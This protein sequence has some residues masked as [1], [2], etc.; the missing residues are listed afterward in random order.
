MPLRLA[1]AV[2]LLALGCAAPVP[3]PAT[4]PLPG[5]DPALQETLRGLVEG[6]EGEVG[7][8]VRHL[9]TGATAE[10]RADE[11]FPTASLIKVP[12]LIGV[13]DAEARGALDLDAPLVYH[14]SLRRSDGDDLAAYLPTG[15]RIA[16]IKLAFLMTALS[17]N[18]ASVW[19]Q[20][21]IRPET[22]N[23]WLERH[24]FERTRLN[25]R[26]PG[27]EEAFRQWGWGQT[28]PRE[29]AELMVWIREGRA[30]SP[31]AS[32]R[33]YRLLSGSFWHE[34]GLAPLP[35]TLQVAS[36]QGAVRRSRSEVMVVESPSGPYVL[37]VITR[38][39][40]DESWGA[41]NAGFVLLR[42]VSDALYRHFNPPP[43]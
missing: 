6:F 27:R 17:D 21:T 41:D 10:V 18:T 23:A 4:S 22:I 3:P 13:F 36:K 40:A 43:S 12:L 19:L 1:P 24:G 9:L 31:E 39:Q 32:A 37:A 25:S 38:N 5:P 34:E 26:T 2:L 35:P 29:I 16:P 7:V 8:Y 15:A 14:D 33:M 42:E 28:S 30:V 20:D 11:T